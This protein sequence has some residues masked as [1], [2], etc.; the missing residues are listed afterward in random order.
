MHSSSLN[1]VPL[2]I[3]QVVSQKFGMSVQK[4]PLYTPVGSKVAR[5]GEGH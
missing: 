5:G 3:E 2:N 1:N 4:L